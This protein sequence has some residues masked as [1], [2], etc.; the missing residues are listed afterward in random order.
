[1]FHYEISEEMGHKNKSFEDLVAEI[2]R[3]SR[4]NDNLIRD[5]EQLQFDLKEKG[6]DLECQ[7]FIS[8][9][10]SD[11]ALTPDEVFIKITAIVSKAFSN[12]VKAEARITF[13][14]KKFD[15]PGFTKSSVT[16]V[17]CIKAN[18]E[19]IGF[20]EVCYPDGKS[21]LIEDSFLKE[22]RDLLLSVALIC[23]NYIAQCEKENWLTSSGRRFR[24][25]VENINDILYEF[26]CNGIISYISPSVERVLGYIPEEVI[27]QN[28]NQFIGKEQDYFHQILNIIHETGEVNSEY[29]I[30]TKNG[31]RRWVAF[32]TKA[33]YADKKFTG[34]AGVLSDITEK[35]KTEIELQRS[36][37]LYR[38]IMNS[39]PDTVTITD[40]EGR[41]ILT[42]PSAYKMF[43]YERAYDFTNH[44]NLEYVE[45]NDHERAIENINKMFAGD[46]PGS[47]E[48]TGIKADGTQFD[49]DV[50]G[51]L[52]LD[53]EGKP[54]YMIFVTRD[55]S[56]RKTDEEKLLKSESRYR[57]FFEWNNS[58]M[59]LI[60]PETGGIQDANPA[61]CDYYGWTHSELT[62]MNISS[63]NVMSAEKVKDEMEKAGLEKKKLFFFNHRLSSGEIRD[64]EVYSGPVSFGDSTYLYSI[65]HDITDRKKAE[66]LHRQS[67]EKYRSLIDSSDAAIT[68]VDK[69]GLYLYLNSNA[70][71]QFGS[72]PEDMVGMSVDDLFP[73]K[74]EEIKGNIVK[75]ID[76]NEGM[77][78]EADV[79]IAGDVYW[80]RTS[81]QPVRNEN[82]IPFAVLMY[83]TDITESKNSEIKIRQSEENY[84]SL[85]F[86]SPVAYLL[87][88]DG[89]FIECNDASATLLA[90]KRSDIIG[91]TPAQ[92]SPEF[93]H[94]G[95][96]SSDY[97]AEV[98][99]EAF[100][101]G[102]HSFEW[103]HRKVNGEEFLALVS[104]SV[105]EYQG[106][107]VVFVVWD[108]ISE[109][110]KADELL[111]KL[112]R[113]V[114]QSPISIVIT[115]INGNIEYANPRACETTGYTLS[116]LLGN[117]P[118]VLQ[119]GE[120]SKNEYIDL[121]NT[122]VSGK[123]WRGLFH[124]KRKNGELYWESA[125]LAPIKDASGKI[126]HYV[127]LKEDITE[128][129]LAEDELRKFRTIID[130]ANYGA[131]ITDING[132]TMYVNKALA[133]M[134]GY[135][136]EEIIGKHLS[137]F[138]NE[139]QLAKV[140]ELLRV[141]VNTGS[142]SSEEVWHTRNDG[143]VFPTLMTG[144]IIYS[145]KNEPLFMSAT[146][147]DITKRKQA[148]DALVSSEE[149][150][151]YAQEIARMGSWDMD[152]ETN[153]IRWSE[154]YYRM[155]G[156]EPYSLNIP[157]DY[158]IKTIHPEDRH[159][160]DEKLH[161]IYEIKK[162]VNTDMRLLMP[163]GSIK[164]VQGNIVPV[165]EGEKLVALKGANIDITEK[166]EAEQKIH[167]LNANLERKVSERT[168]ELAV[169]NAY[170]V[171]EI[172]ERKKAE[173]LL[174]V[175]SE[176]L[177]NFFSVALDLLCIADTSGNFIKVNK[178]WANILGYSVTDLEQR[179][180]LDFVHPDDMQATLD[181]M[182]NLSLQNPILNFINRYRTN[183]GDY[184]FIE[185]HSVPVGNLIYAAARDITER[186]INEEAL[187]KA[188]RVAEKANMSKSE[189]LAN[190]SHE[191]R[192]PMNAVL[193]Y[194]EL[195]ASTRVDSVQKDYINSIKS[196][197]KSLLTIINDI[198]D[199]SK[200]EA[201]KLE[202]DYDFTNTYGF[203][204]E[205]EQ[206]FAFRINEKGIKFSLYIESGTP[207]GI[208]IDEAR[209]RQIVFNL[210]GN[211][212][213]F[214]FKGFIRLSVF[215][216]N[217]RSI[218]Y[219][220]GKV[221]DVL[222]LVIEVE[223]SGIGISDAMHETIFEPF[224]QEQNFRRF[225]GTG[226]GL[227]ICKRLV[228]LMNGTITLKSELEKG[229]TFTIR[230]PETA[231]L[232]EFDISQQELQIDPSRVVFEKGV[233]LVVDDIQHNRDYLIDV[234]KSTELET[235]EAENGAIG[236]EMALKLLPDLIITDIR[237]PVM[238]GFELLE[239]IKGDPVA[240]KIP[241]LA[242]SASVLK[243]QRE[244]IFKA[245]FA[246][247]LIKPV[248]ISDLY[249][250]LMS[251]LPFKILNTSL[252]DANND[253]YNIE[254]IK[255]ISVL[256]TA[257]ERDFLDIW[258]T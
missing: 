121:W 9:I 4:L 83:S 251:I 18:N 57:T 68:M 152:L 241:V 1:M 84:R 225:G 53:Q 38:S 100:R 194:S 168:I 114:D 104:L 185:W 58:V 28:L 227:A 48:Y 12:G 20:F 249:A 62:H 156:L 52:I 19:E 210:I 15:T 209:L 177:E 37:L 247:L 101:I 60:E 134:H 218:E 122:L 56:Q 106:K 61:A 140:S 120:T 72:H 190:M 243:A 40:L 196:S 13:R 202:L 255:N 21:G 32:S 200:I 26:D 222:D 110:R 216:E 171:K 85:F 223:D 109:K 232:R 142:F 146:A 67:E 191:I 5:N 182:Q 151:N 230:I 96:S 174:K 69:E 50:N 183:G 98:I 119:S 128:K 214:T 125:T 167:E 172:E 244:K 88:S 113:A 169:T 133:G 180:F 234:L 246:G 34:G 256:L 143:S 195:L 258:R 47:V 107:R 136:P 242:Y 157:Y 220:E 139:E 189:F 39:V 212:A 150:L 105:V 158:F 137:I 166:K 91:K 24:N 205:F 43:G 93:Q 215:T 148:E 77:L 17:Q 22:K 239:K 31:E 188:K 123:E 201:G 149:T 138:H 207:N 108:D 236:Y 165:F 126:T 192:T 147:I 254:E 30:S 186:I 63:L 90:G 49:I 116:D 36:E 118:R 127:A 25:L 208:C 240:K 65:V 117:N 112:S 233:I 14:E 87:V 75:V 198:L 135:K 141:L 231:Y 51:E 164:W 226:L 55:I 130:E 253:L 175:K 145:E 66:I 16:L 129:K 35:K 161:E 71:K 184:R 70:A 235:Y 144:S 206:I 155:L 79:N 237:M 80:F 33:V 7:S 203:F 154:N 248:K 115:N 42:S 94:N 199:I 187:Q 41:I 44:T 224:V 160:I 124:N 78:I 257:L 250:A 181:S 162:S 97:S 229:S 176:E 81:V 204:S 159:L 2:T 228:G 213:K 74:A 89:I 23:G 219:T 111:R 46:L 27:G 86:N 95:K 170:L 221:T 3:L 211:A 8:E 245:N 45:G 238:T 29:E 132:H 59:L 178:A 11:S 82:G 92:I 153:L 103:I 6:K 252:T 197:G 179:K 163:D 73:D 54:V 102:S 173:D 64:V 10:F 217:P 76:Q 193:G 131:S 99:E